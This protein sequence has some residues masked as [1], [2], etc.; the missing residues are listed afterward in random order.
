MNKSLINKYCR[1]FGFEI[2]GNGYMRS[3]L[4]S[5]FKVDAFQSQKELVRQRECMIFDVGAN[6]G[7]TVAQYLELFPEAIIH[8][9]EP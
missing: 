9:F 7:N 8:A 6:R 2:H 3:L 5:S 1:K 4:K